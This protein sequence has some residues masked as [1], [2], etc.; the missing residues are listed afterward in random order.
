[1]L[2]ANLRNSHSLP[3]V[4]SVNNQ[5]M[6]SASNRHLTQEERKHAE[7]A[8]KLN[9][10]EFTFIFQTV[11]QNFKFLNLNSLVVDYMPPAW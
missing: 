9:S 6:A 11:M 8:N 1:M 4:S 7:H 2:T 5:A 3:L 10:W